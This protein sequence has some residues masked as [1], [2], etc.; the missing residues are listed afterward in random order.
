[1]IEYN[2]VSVAEAIRGNLPEAE[3]YGSGYD[4]YED[5]Y[6]YL[7][8]R[9]EDKVPMELIG[10]DGGEP[11]DQ[12]FSRDWAWVPRALN[13]AFQLGLVKGSNDKH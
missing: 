7:L 13:E 1:M 3:D 5:E 10:S 11:E 9:F 6:R 2:L 8:Y 4:G 12:T